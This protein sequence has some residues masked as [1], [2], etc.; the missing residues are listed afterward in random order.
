MYFTTACLLIFGLHISTGEDYYDYGEPKN[1]EKTESIIGGRVDYPNG[2]AVGSEVTYHCKDGFKPYPVSK[3]ICNSEGKWEPKISRVICEEEDDYEDYDETP[4]KNCSLAE[5]INGGHVTY[6]NEGL[7]GSVLTYHCGIGSYPY[8]FRRRV[9]QRGEW[10]VMVLPNGKRVSTATCR[11]ILC[12]A[13]LKLDSGEFWPKKQWFKVGEEQR[14]SCKEGLTLLGSAQRNCTEWG[15]WT[16]TTPVCND[17]SDYCGNPVTPPGAL[18]SGD[19]FRIGDKVKYSCQSGLDLLGPEVRECLDSKEWSGPVPRCQAHF[20][21]DSPETVAQ[22]MH[23]SL[24]VVLDVLSPEFKM[25]AQQD[26]GRTLKVADGRLNIFILMDTSGSILQDQF[27]NAKK[28]TANLI[29]KL[30]SYDVQMKFNIISYATEPRDIIRIQDYGSDNVEIVLNKLTEF[31]QTTHGRKTGT[32]LYK[33][34]YKVY[35]QLSFLG[36]SKKEK[37]FNETQNV[38]LIETDGYSNMGGSIEHVLCMIREHLGYKCRSFDNTQED[39]LDIY[40]FGIGENV[41]KDELRNIASMKMREQHLFILHTYSDLGEVFNRM[42]NDSAVTKCGMAQ[43]LVYPRK[44]P[45]THEDTEAPQPAYTRPWHVSVY[46]KMRPCKGSILTENWLMTAA[47]CLMKL[48]DG[49]VEHATTNELHIEHGEGKAAASLL[50]IHPQFDVSGLK[51]KNIKEFYDYDI[52]LIKV[53]NSI[54]L[55]IKARPIC[56]P[57]TKA[58]NRALRLNHDSTCEKH[59][60]ALIDP[61]ETQAHFIR[62]GKIR[63]QTHIQS[64][65]RVECMEQYKPALASNNLVALTDVITERF[66]CTGGSTK[67]KDDFTCKGDSGGALFLRKAMRYFQVGVVSWGIKSLCNSTT[68]VVPDPPRDARDFHISVF[69]IMPWLQQHLGKELEFLPFGNLN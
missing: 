42:I 28:A 17:K 55:S 27:E 40:V 41:K 19:R 18:R 64:E 29:R 37:Y 20:A 8:P 69:A 62:Q 15:H 54:K 52:A 30:S 11:E 53:V 6:S 4:Q 7:E 25:K 32:N 33:A 14:F 36:A 1:C 58:S 44:T 67:H 49:F 63:L 13:Q 2:V 9:C 26:Y 59:K 65:K 56:L 46:W 48:T 5:V 3:K 38:I 21:F 57:C 23:G 47:H 10:S 35:E 50:I 12:P 66:L 68:K 24:S 22:A 45:E 51:D 60:S 61:K 43:E 31:S 39:L 34:L 16:G